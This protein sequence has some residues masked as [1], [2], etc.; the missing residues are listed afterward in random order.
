MDAPSIVALLRTVSRARSIPMKRLNLIVRANVPS[1]L[2][3]TEQERMTRL[4]LGRLLD[5]SIDLGPPPHSR[6]AKVRI[7]AT[8]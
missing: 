3:A 7:I 6:R 8:K 5:G 1:D 4:I 2:S